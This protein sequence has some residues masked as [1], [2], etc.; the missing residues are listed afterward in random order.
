MWSILSKKGNS[1]SDERIR[2]IEAFDRLFPDAEIAFICGD[3]EF[4]GKAW[5]R[6]LLL[7]PSMAFRL[8]I[9]QSDRIEHKGKCLPVRVLFSHLRKGE[10]QQ[11]QGDAS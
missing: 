4:I 3:R 2:L 1:N 5:V 6:Y 8:R 9:R 11:L 7:S 10:S